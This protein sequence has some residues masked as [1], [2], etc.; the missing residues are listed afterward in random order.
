M[1]KVAQ[2][3]LMH[4]LL[5]W[6]IDVGINNIGPLAS[7]EQV[8][9]YHAANTNSVEDAIESLITWHTAYAAGTGFLTGLGGIA[10]LPLTIPTSLAMSYAIGANTAAA[11]AHLR[12]YD[13]D[14]TQVRTMILLCL[15]GE[16]GEEVLRTAG[17]S[18]GTQIA[19]N[20]INQIPR[21]AL[22]EINKKVG[23]R[24]VSNA[25]EK[26][27][28]NLMKFVP[29]VGGIVGATCD[30]SFV[31]LCGQSAKQVFE[32]QYNNPI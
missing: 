32:Q 16:A 20:V 19:K 3:D 1:T 25:G 24:L 17:I 10:A 7:A 23:F 18:M 28:I 31:N 6:I 22:V 30:S 29:V 11:I 26:G 13:V 21:K 12:G 2:N 9:V 8:A 15:I 14:S 5:H 27:A 4:Q